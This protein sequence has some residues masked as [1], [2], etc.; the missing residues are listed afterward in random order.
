MK[1]S[2]TI[3]ANGQVGDVLLRNV[4]VV[5]PGG[6]GYQQ[7]DDA[8][9]RLALFNKAA[10]PD[11][12][13][14]VRTDAAT[15]ASLLWDAACDGESEQ[16]QRLP[17]LADGGVTRLSGSLLQY[18]VQLDGFTREVQAGTEIPMTFRF[19]QA[20]EVS[21]DVPV[22]AV[23]DLDGAG[24][25]GDCPA[26]G[27]TSSPPS[28]E[29]VTLRGTVRS[30]VEAGCLVMESDGRQYLL[31]GGNSAVVKPGAEVVLEGVARQGQATTCQQ[32]IPFEI[33]RAEP[34]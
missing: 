13:V 15:N 9:V 19:E 30:G 7:G 14:D 2:G 21:L 1:E 31:L 29:A 34:A 18:R 22:E 8:A 28:P 10:R 24:H 20:G 11:A 6:D 32:G 3:G 4:H 26:A 16:V 17:L 27:A 23:A 25:P 33:A 5:P 12:L